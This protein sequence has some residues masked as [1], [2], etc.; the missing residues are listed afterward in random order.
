MYLYETHLHTFPVSDCSI[1][2]VE[3]MMEFY[4][5]MNYDGIFITN[6]FIDDSF[7]GNQN[8]PYKE[9]IDFFFSDYEK[10]KKLSG[11]IGIKV[12]YGLEASYLGTDF[13]VYGLD[14]EWFLSHPE[15][16]HM[17][18]SE[19]LPYYMEHGALVVQA[20][21]FR[22][23]GYIDHI[24]LFPRCVQGI[25]VV[26]ASRTEFEN[27]AALWY[28]KYYGLLEFAGTDNHGRLKTYLAG[29]SSETP[30]T[31]EKDFVHKVLT[32]Q[33]QLF[34]KKLEI[35]FKNTNLTTIA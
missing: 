35:P 24:R 25:E 27:E 4:K 1:V 22:E 2:S 19:V 33:M 21:P 3:K 8:M 16:E 18:K 34:T 29:M 14:K 17:E 11:E 10:G 32:G 9:R 26:N 13:L 15:I 5:L 6:H 31:D 20:H 7:G 28:A 30:V 23:A 12:F